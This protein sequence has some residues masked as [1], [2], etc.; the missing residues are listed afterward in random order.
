MTC[1]ITDDPSSKDVQSEKTATIPAEMSAGPKPHSPQETPGERHKKRRRFSLCL[2]VITALGALVAAIAASLAA[3]ASYQQ[4][5]LTRVQHAIT[6][7]TAQAQLADAKDTSQKQLR[8]YVYAT[9][10]NLYHLGNSP[11]QGYVT[12]QNAGNTFAKDVEIEAGINVLGAEIPDDLK[13][14][15]KLDQEPGVMPLAPRSP[16]SFFR[17]FRILSDEQVKEIKSKKKRIYVF[18]K[19]T[20]KDMFDLSHQ[21]TFCF[22]YYGPETGEFKNPTRDGYYPTQAKYHKKHNHAD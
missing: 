5:D 21:T 4:L 2:K 15:G 3:R 12:I 17:E 6:K 14:M 11:T 1:N 16:Y 8:A 10:N 19:V 20:Y 18:G 9:P 22:M 7:N 13:K